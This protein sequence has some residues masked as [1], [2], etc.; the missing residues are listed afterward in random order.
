MTMI[1]IWFRQTEEWGTIN[2]DRYIYMG[3][4]TRRVS[5]GIVKAR[6]IGKKCSRIR[7]YFS[8]QFSNCAP[9]ISAHPKNVVTGGG[10]ACAIIL[11]GRQQDDIEGYVNR[12]S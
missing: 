2:D 7:Q 5:L 10:K 11:F 9:L 4:V 1:V 6:E 8:R 12:S 3:K